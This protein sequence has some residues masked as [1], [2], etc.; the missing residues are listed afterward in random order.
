MEFNDQTTP[1]AKSGRPA[2]H[3]EAR[4][5]RGE[6]WSYNKIARKF[7]LSTTAVYF[8]FF[9][10]KR[11]LTK[12]KKNEKAINSIPSAVGASPQDN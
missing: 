1:R 10:E 9:P 3:D 8:L 5:L 11:R 12:A 4:R 6:G 2:W 7:D